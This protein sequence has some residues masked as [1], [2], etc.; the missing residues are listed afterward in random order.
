MLA[1]SHQSGDCTARFQMQ[2]HPV[3]R[4]ANQ[5]ERTLQLLRAPS[6]TLSAVGGRLTSLDINFHSLTDITSTIA[7]LSGVFHR[8]FMAA[9]NLIAIRLCFPIKVPLDLEL[10]VLF[11]HI[12]W[13]PLRTLSIQG[14]RLHASEI[15]ALV[16]RH[17]RQLHHFCLAGIYLREGTSQW[18]DVLTVLRDEMEQLERVDLRE[19]DYASNFDARATTTGVE[20]FDNHYH[21]TTTAGGL[22][23]SVAVAASTASTDA[24]S[25]PET[26]S[27]PGLSVQNTYKP[28]SAHD[29]SLERLRH[30]PIT[31][32]GDNVSS[33]QADQLPFWEA[34]A[35]SGSRRG[36][37]NGQC[38][39]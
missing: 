29:S 26:T 37:R 28:G 6:T 38:G 35:L 10:E 23:S 39:S 17:S 8:F 3:H 19:L 25:T 33:V 36:F 9:T 16:R 32:L 34:W 20:V 30:I 1:C 22:P 11:H 7:D 15:I 4:G 27:L 2:L 31:E 14:W 13:K 24:H 21:T 5:P 18:H 12:R